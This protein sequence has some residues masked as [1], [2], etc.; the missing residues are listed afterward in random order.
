M[1]DRLRYDQA[2]SISCDFDGVLSTLVLGRRWVKTKARK[3]SLPILSPLNEGLKAVVGSLTQAFRGP[4]PHAD[5]VLRRLRSSEKALYVLT[6]RTGSGVG[7]ARRWLERQG[8][9]GLFAESFF[10]VDSEDADPF[11]ARVLRA[12]AIDVHIDDDPETLAYLA[13][14]F[15]EKLFVYMN[16]YKRKTS[17]TAPNIIVVQSWQDLAAVLDPRAPARQ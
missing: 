2:R 1:G 4:F 15:P 8:W 7:L 14:E 3:R 10:N 13:G 16:C 9:Q 17:L 5:E 11:K 12:N 6:S